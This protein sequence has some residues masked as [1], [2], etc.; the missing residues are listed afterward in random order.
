MGNVLKA[1]MGKHWDYVVI[2]DHSMGPINHPELTR[3]YV[4]LIAAQARLSGAQPILYL[5]W[6]REYNPATQAQLDSVYTQLAVQNH[7]LLAPVGQAWQKALS[8]SPKPD[9]YIYDGSHP[10]YSGSYL[11]ASVFYSLIYGQ[12]PPLPTQADAKRF[13]QVPADSLQ[14]D[15]WSALQAQN[16]ALRTLPNRLDMLATAQDKAR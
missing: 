3:K 4:S 15:A 8:E 6:A 10:T 11:A 1:M 7:A 5:T 9:L 2:Q 12:R 13:Q 14:Q 16:V